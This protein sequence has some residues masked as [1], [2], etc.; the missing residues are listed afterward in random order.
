MDLKPFPSFPLRLSVYTFGHFF[1]EFTANYFIIA[2]IAPQI[3]SSAQMI[4]VL[5]FY[6]LFDYGFQVLIGL[7]DDIVHRNHFFAACGAA[8]FII[9]Y[10]CSPI[11]NL[12]AAVIGLGAAF[13][14][15]P[16]GRQVLLDRPHSYAPLA[17]FV[18]SGAFGVFLGRRAGFTSLPL[19]WPVLACAIVVLALLIALGTAEREGNAH[20]ETENA[21][22]S[23]RFTK[24]GIVAVLILVLTVAV[25]SFTFAILVFPWD[26]GALAWLAAI[27][28]MLGKAVGGFFAD[29]FGYRTTIIG[30]SLVALAAAAFAPSYPILGLI[31][32]FALNIPSATLISRIAKRLAPALGTGFGLYK[33]F[34]LVGFFPT[35]FWG[36]G[37]PVSPINLILLTIVIGGLMLAE[38]QL[39]E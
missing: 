16:L 8:L 36:T 12:M 2:L 1:F 23:L 34:H 17:P 5:L 10:F 11:P 25:Q 19:S 4:E 39:K 7:V 21:T 18:A 14:H 37:H 38:G 26:S 28:I 15:V 30:S 6:N 35:L 3:S 9:G 24:I 29:R 32:L 33:F 20:A 31:F 27:T 13:I 22:K